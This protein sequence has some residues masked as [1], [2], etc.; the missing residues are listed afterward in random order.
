MYSNFLIPIIIF[1]P[2][3]GFVSEYGQKLANKS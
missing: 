1:K 3:S 2:G